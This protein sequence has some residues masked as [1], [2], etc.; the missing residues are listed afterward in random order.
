MSLPNYLAKI[1]SSGV[2][3]YVFDLS[4]IPTEERSTLRLVVGYSERGPFNTPV[5]IEEPSEFI[6]TFGNV[7]RRMERKGIYFHRMA[8]QALQAGPILA[9]NLK[10]F[11]EEKSTMLSFDASE[12][13]ATPLSG[14]EVVAEAVAK[15]ED[16]ISQTKKQVSA[17]QA[18]YKA[19]STDENK[20]AWETAKNDLTELNTQKEALLA[21]AETVQKFEQETKIEPQKALVANSQQSK[22]NDE[23]EAIYDTNRFWKV[24]DDLM[25]IKV[26]KDSS[27]PDPKK[28]LR[29]VQTG[30]KED[31][32]TLFIRPVVPSGYDVKISDWYSA[33]TAEEMPPYMEAIKDHYLS[34]FFA[35]IYVFRGNLNNKSLFAETGTLGANKVDA[36]GNSDWQPFCHI[37]DD[38]VLRTNPDYINVFGE[39]ADAL[40]AMANVTTSNFVNRY[41]G[42]LFPNFKSGTGSFI[43]LDSVFNRDYNMHKCLLAFNESL[44]DD[45]YEMEDDQETISNKVHELCSGGVATSDNHTPSFNAEETAVIGYYLEGYEYATIQRKNN[46]KDLQ[47]KIFDVLG[48]KGIFE[49]LTNNVDSDW[50]YFVDTFQTYAGPA[51]KANIAAICKQKFNCLGILN[52]PTIM[53][54]AIA[55]GYPG[56]RGGFDMKKVTDSISSG[57][58]LPTETQGA[59]FV[60]FYTQLQFTDG[61]N[62]FYV[63]SAALVSN[64]F[65]EKLNLRQKYDIVAG[66][67]YG[68]IT[69][70]GLVGPDY[71]YARNDLDALEPFGVN[72]I[73]YIPRKGVLVN[74]NQTAKQTPVT[75]LSKVNVRELVTFLQDELEDM[76]YGYQW[77]LN[78]STL[79]DKIETKARQILELCK[80]NGG[81]YDFDAKCDDTNNTPEIIDNEMV[82]LEVDIEAARGAGKMVQILR[83]HRTGGL[84][85]LKG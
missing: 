19:E 49:A 35:E 45:A 14:K 31:S 20:K 69:Y 72:A 53:D 7:S 40:E 51:M 80:A 34:E 16:L 63:P 60:A 3:R 6:N 32:V 18:T 42:I 1:K 79:R 68:R 82:V 46:G 28:Y 8:L 61:S 33:D 48:Y 66:P 36:D 73:V 37:D 52:F 29:I 38:G 54:C 43:S 26:A 41:Q 4:E 21:A 62:K 30:S 2:Y 27:D 74:S 17:T 22:P 65:I 59:S 75:A 5:Y 84:A 47:K 55:C 44:L 67:N 83:L 11:N 50:K 81:I 57:I 76:L 12:I 39:N 15:V 9:L 71:N 70:S 13:A 10:P 78:T 77:Q 85:N 24:N 25:S 64:L 23:P 58:S 56:L